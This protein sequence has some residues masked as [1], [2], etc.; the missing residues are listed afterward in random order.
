MKVNEFK[1]QLLITKLRDNL[2]QKQFFKKL[3]Y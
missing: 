3:Q 1:K 2:I